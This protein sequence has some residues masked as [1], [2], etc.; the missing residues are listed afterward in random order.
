MLGRPGLVDEDDA[1][2]EETAFSGNPG[3]D[4]IG[5]D[6]RDAARIIGVSHILLACDLLAGGD[7]P[8]AKLGLQA[9]VRAAPAASRHDELSVERAPGIH[10]RRNVRIGDLLDEGFRIDRRQ[11]GRAA[12]IIG[13]DAGRLRAGGGVA[14]ERG[15]GDRDRLEFAPPH[16]EIAILGMRRG[17]RSGEKGEDCD[18]HTEDLRR[19]AAAILQMGYFPGSCCQSMSSGSKRTI[20][21]F[22]WS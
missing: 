18:Q 8:E 6:M 9:A 1:R 12:E 22:H 14:D 17:E 5:Y 15:H 3:E 10:V 7:V 4:R 2:I 21:P 13:D 11:K 16:V 20:R 19:R